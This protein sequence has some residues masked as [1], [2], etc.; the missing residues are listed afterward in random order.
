M[1]YYT[2]NTNSPHK[3]LGKTSWFT[4]R[5]AL[6]TY[7]FMDKWS[8]WAYTIIFLNADYTQ[9]EFSSVMKCFLIVE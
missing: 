3:L 6:N 9:N 1:H 4:H 5:Q 2:L 7:A 8:K